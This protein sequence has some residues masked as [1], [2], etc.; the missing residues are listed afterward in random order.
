M[1]EYLETLKQL[2]T[3]LGIQEE[4][5]EEWLSTVSKGN[6]DILKGILTTCRKSRRV[7][8]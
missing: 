7:C 6:E 2:T 1:E 8:N 3:D 5:Y 4:E